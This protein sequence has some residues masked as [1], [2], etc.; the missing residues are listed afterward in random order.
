MHL[1]SF[2]LQEGGLSLHES[3][4]SQKLNSG[5]LLEATVLHGS[6]YKAVHLELVQ[7]HTA[8]HHTWA[9]HPGLLG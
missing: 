4:Q 7:W 3:C 5:L 2:A 6:H 1:R 9:R 8:A